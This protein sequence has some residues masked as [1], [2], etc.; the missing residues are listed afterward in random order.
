[1]TRPDPAAYRFATRRSRIVGYGVYIYITRGVM[2]DTA[3]HA[4]RRSV[5]RLVDERRPTGILITHHHEDHA[6]N[7]EL[8]RELGV[9]IEAPAA[10]LA[11]ARAPDSIG[12]YRRFVWSSMPAL[13]GRVVPFEHPSLELLPAP[14]H[15]ADH[16]VVWDAE[17]ATLFSA[18]L[19]LGVKVRVARPGEDPR[20]LARS[21]R[22]IA[23]L[24]P[25]R[26]FDAHRGEV[27]RPVASLL[28]K[29]DWLDDTIAQ[30]DRHLGAGLSDGAIVRAVFGREAAVRYVS[31]GDLS[32]MNF[33]RSVRGTFRDR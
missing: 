24:R 32:R 28:A 7:I 26:M 1:M 12:I 23:A 10:T 18:D 15:S 21:L 6:G 19:Y 30:V 5:A 31:N 17:R 2:I 8:G 16:H 14:G 3:F 25:A 11:L 33:V 9:P 20:V 29:A 27:G 22:S 13:R 4:V